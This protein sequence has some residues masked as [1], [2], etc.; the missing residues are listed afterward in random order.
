[1]RN[2]T[3]AAL[4]AGLF[5]G[6]ATL[7]GASAQ[8]PPTAAAHVTDV[9]TVSDLASVCQPSST[10]VVRLESIAYCQGFITAAGQYHASLNPPGR[11]SRPMFC[12]PDPRP[13]VAQAGVAFAAWAGANPGRAGEPALDG[14]LRWA[15]E[16]YPCPATPAARPAARR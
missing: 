5:A 9:R 14:L 8:T 10:G 13:T 12:P 11:S 6:A 1:M 16:T 7:P 15:G 3:T 2:T 4:L